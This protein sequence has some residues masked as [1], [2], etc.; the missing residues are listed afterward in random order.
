MPLPA[1]MAMTQVT[2][3]QALPLVDSCPPDIVQM[4][5]ELQ[6]NLITAAVAMGLQHA[7][8]IE[9]GSDRLAH[10][11]ACSITMWQC[12]ALRAWLAASC[13]PLS[14]AVHLPFKQ[15]RK[16]CSSALPCCEQSMTAAACRPSATSHQH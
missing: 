7:P 4:P 1:Q 3:L 2:S 12:F 13:F 10:R 8:V 9:P 15:S 14:K 6:P 11:W 16:A 5:Q